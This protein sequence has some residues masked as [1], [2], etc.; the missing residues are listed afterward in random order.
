MDITAP[1][2]RPEDLLLKLSHAISHATTGED[3]LNALKTTKATILGN[4]NR[5][6]D[7]IE[8]SVLGALTSLLEARI[9]RGRAAQDYDKNDIDDMIL[10]SNIPIDDDIARQVALIIGMLANSGPAFIYPVFA[11]GCIPLLFSMLAY[12]V[13]VLRIAVLETLVSIADN[14][15][16][17]YERIWPPGKDL[18]NTAFSQPY[19]S[20]L[21]DILQNNPQPSK[22]TP[23]SKQNTITSSRCF[24]LVANLI[25]KICLEPHHKIMLGHSGAV[26][27][28]AYKIASFVVAQGLVLPGADRFVKNMG[29]LGYLPQPTN[30]DSSVLTATLRAIGV[31]A[32]NSR[33]R[34]EHFLASPG[35]VTVFPRE[36]CKTGL[37]GCSPGGEGGGRNCTQ[38]TATA[39]SRPAWVPNSNIGRG[40]SLDCKYLNP[41][42]ALLPPFKYS[43][44]LET[45]F[46]S[47]SSA[48]EMQSSLNFSKDKFEGL[49]KQDA[50]NTGE[51]KEESPFVSWLLYMIFTGAAAAVGNHGLGCRELR[52]VTATLLLELFDLHLVKEM[53]IPVLSSLV[54]PVLMRIVEGGFKKE[55][56][57]AKESK[58]AHDDE[59]NHFSKRAKVQLDATVTLARLMKSIRD[60]TEAQVFHRQEAKLVETIAKGLQ[61]TFVAEKEV[62][63]PVWNP[64]RSDQ[65]SSCLPDL[66]TVNQPLD[67]S[68]A[69]G[70]SGLSKFSVSQNA[71]RERYL[72]ALASMA[73]YGEEHRAKFAERETLACVMN[74][75][76]AHEIEAP[77]TTLG[78]RNQAGP[79]PAHQHRDS[80]LGNTAAPA[81]DNSN[82][83]KQRPE[84]EY[85]S[86]AVIHAACMAARALC[87]SP[88]LLRTVL[89][90]ADMSKPPIKLLSHPDVDIK[91]AATAVLCNLTLDFSPMKQN[92]ME[93][94]A[95][96]LLCAHARSNNIKLQ[97]ESFWALKHVVI[98]QT[99]QFR[100]MV[101]NELGVAA[102]LNAMAQESRALIPHR[103]TGEPI[104]EQANVLSC[105]DADILPARYRPRAIE[106]PAPQPERR[107]ESL[108]KVYSSIGTMTRD[109][110]LQ[111]E[112]DLEY[113]SQIR[114]DKAELVEQSIDL[115]RNLICGGD[116]CPI[117]LDH[118][119]A[120]SGD[121]RLFSCL[122][123]RL[124]T[125]VLH[126]D[127]FGDCPVDA[128][129]EIVL[130]ISYTLINFSACST[131][132]ANI[133]V[134]RNRLMQL[135]VKLLSHHMRRVRCNATWTLYNLV[136]AGR[137]VDP[138]GCKRRASQVAQ[139]GV[140]EKLHQLQ[141]EDLDVD[142][143]ERARQTIGSLRELLGRR[144][145]IQGNGGMNGNGNDNGN[146]I[147]MDL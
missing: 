28:L 16:M 119:I 98:G 71:M 40:L 65:E 13:P 120:Q 5:K 97:I 85:N 95:V 10:S 53:R 105:Y 130:T 9:T 25:S 49:E 2:D 125:Y 109:E 116:H 47:L 14:L 50:M 18:A 42:D 141:R 12:P 1:P 139:L 106:K 56:G 91:L 110:K 101:L 82:S 20:Y 142:V 99:N 102:V 113:V 88:K 8:G 35:I 90:E 114:K 144:A 72:M 140:E 133:V 6:K 124:D 121:E 46:P 7:L 74:S 104:S 48:A 69:L 31:I 117:V 37:A 137:T 63:K 123:K 77:M 57:L 138:E 29:S 19:I 36:A 24:K 127:M 107:P 100:M 32:A 55:K 41:V 103:D 61:K 17:D 89:K 131:I 59:D 93:E 60:R 23:Q 34:A 45:S 143:R 81:A 58:K 92:I 78:E 67:S 122:T 129:D 30:E 22:I 115:I 111:L 94:K 52:V 75:M 80:N 68:T 76:K 84:I 4:E 26:N 62:G 145:P 38:S 70:P 51:V 27:A 39:W 44:S 108:M 134:S 21:V 96:S 136:S 15:P 54:V 87:R 147:D 126:S 79:Q 73:V 146:D 3:R 135:I 86:I 64:Q 66:S 83:K 132:H 112:S 128:P 43:E 11:A 33:G 118:I